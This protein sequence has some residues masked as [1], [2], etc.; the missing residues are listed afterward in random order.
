MQHAVVDGGGA[1]VLMSMDAV[2]IWVP[3]VVD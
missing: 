2:R 3:D 1:G